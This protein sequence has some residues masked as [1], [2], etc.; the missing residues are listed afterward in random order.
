[1]S[2]GIAL[3][4]QSC[5]HSRVD[6]SALVENH[7]VMSRLN[8]FL[9]G[10][11]VIDLSRHLPGPFATLLLADMGA[12]VLKI[13]PPAGDDL[14]TIGPAGPCGRSIYFDAVN[15]GKITH[16]IDL[17]RPDARSKFL[18]LVE[19]ADVLVESFRPGVMT[20]LGLDY[21]ALKQRNPA[22][23]YC[24]VSGFGASGPLAQKAAHDLN[25]LSLSGANSGSATG[26]PAMFETLF[27][28]NA[29]ALFTALAIVGA[30]HARVHDGKGCHIDLALA[31][32]V[33]PLQL[34]QLVGLNAVGEAAAGLAQLNGG[35]ASYRIYET[36]DGNRVSL[37]A[38][39]HRFWKAF[40]EAAGR[41]E[42]I[43]RQADPLPQTLLIGEVSRMFGML[44]LEECERRFGA[45]DCCFSPILD[46][47]AAVD[48]PH[49]RARGVVHRAADGTLHPLFPALV[50]G[51]SPAPREPL[52]E[53]ESLP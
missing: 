20:R 18:E 32:A 8:K 29:G 37:A 48:S 21:E 34:F 19:R 44:S 25:Y 51:E 7:G 10:V 13:E 45:A 38:V 31:D 46:L 52:R 53:D 39:E 30:L 6:E 3:P 50:D 49:V 23:I 14:R 5:Q 41:P 22:L 40:C 33:M 43:S 17:K 36:A 24:S 9:A 2:R 26:E 35:S 42:W 11:S 15:A 47:R 27:A 4:R 1:V 12:E 28:D 16:R